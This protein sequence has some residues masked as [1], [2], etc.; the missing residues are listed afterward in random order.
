MT[1]LFLPLLLADEKLTS[2]IMVVD[3]GTLFE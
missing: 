3:R 2:D 1:D